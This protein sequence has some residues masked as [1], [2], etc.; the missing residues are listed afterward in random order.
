MLLKVERLVAVAIPAPLYNAFD[1]RVGEGMT[2]RAG[3][4]LRVPFGA[5]EVTGIALDA[6]REAPA[7]NDATRKYK[8]V[9]EVLDA[10]PLLP[11]ALLELSRFAAEYYQHPL[12]EVL[13]TALPSALRQG[14]DAALKAPQGLRIT[15]AGR[16]ALATLPKRSRAQR[17]LLEALAAAPAARAELPEHSPAALRRLL[18]EGWSEWF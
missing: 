9:A 1:Y 14:G 2:I 15:P 3:M 5:R 12:G 4:R 13:A 6:P 11:E 16:E 7:P 18:D 17:A 10:E 8:A